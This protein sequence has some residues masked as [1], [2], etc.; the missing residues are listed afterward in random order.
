MEEKASE[1]YWSRVWENS[2]PPPPVD[3]GNVTGVGKAYQEFFRRHLA[4]LARNSSILEIGCGGSIWLPYF[5]KQYG[6]RIA[7][8]DY[9]KK[10]CLKAKWILQRDQCDGSIYFGDAFDPPDEL[11]Q[12]FDAV[13][14]MGFVEHFDDT[15][16]CLRAI[17]RY[18]KPGG[19]VLTTIPNVAGLIGKAQ[20]FLER[21][22]YYRHVAITVEDMQ[23]AALRA[24]LELAE[25]RYAGTLDFHICNLGVTNNRSIGMFI[26]LIVWH[27]LMRVSRMLWRVER[28]V[29][30]AC[31]RRTASAIVCAARVPACSKA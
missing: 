28:I 24:G 18:V 14:S 4:G 7:G 22:V 5:N 12:S 21:S 13:V 3:P 16:E 27:V 17:G 1:E 25:C 29:P 9:S 6:L 15:A 8:I 10:G 19:F 26:R 30:L 31:T 20:Y 23:S 11:L 2:D